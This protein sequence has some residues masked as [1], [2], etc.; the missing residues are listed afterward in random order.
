[1]KL[2]FFS[3]TDV[4]LVRSN[5][6]DSLLADGENR[7]FIVADGMGGHKGGEVASKMAVQIVSKNIANNI[8]KAGS[9]VRSIKLACAEANQ[10][11][12]KKGQK[13][14][15]LRGMGTTLCAFIIKSDGLAYIVNVG[16]SR[17]YM[18]KDNQMWLL[19]EDH[20]FITA[21]I[22]SNFLSG[23]SMPLEPSPED[24]VLTKSVGFFPRIEPDIVEKN[25]EK[26]ERYLICS[27]GL[28][29]LVPEPEIHEILKTPDLKSVPKKCIKRALDSGGND[30][31]SV[32]VIEV[33]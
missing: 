2:E 13:D 17:L 14:I 32:I 6:Q 20:N 25:V 8:K 16:D 28:S 12:Y 27:D 18:Q 5:N 22:K 7:I 23:E 4:G 19:T 11:I 3:A 26:G 10:T 33:Q 29:G 31:I 9:L 21:Q 24:N 30:N 1:M 15:N